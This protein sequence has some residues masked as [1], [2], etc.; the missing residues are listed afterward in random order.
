MILNHFKS[1]AGE[2]F[3]RLTKEEWRSNQCNALQGIIKLNM[4]I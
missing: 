3:I 2:E 1:R 4:V